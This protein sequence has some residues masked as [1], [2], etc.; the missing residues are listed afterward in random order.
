MSGSRLTSALLELGRAE[1][2]GDRDRGMRAREEIL[3]LAAVGSDAVAR[4]ESGEAEQLAPLRAPDVR[5]RVAA[6]QASRRPVEGTHPAVTAATRT[7]SG[8]RGRIDGQPARLYT[9]NGYRSI[10]RQLAKNGRV[11]WRPAPDGAGYWLTSE[12]AATVR[13]VHAALYED[14]HNAEEVTT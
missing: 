11:E 4:E 6:F 10:V 14:T 8:V 13:K 1:F 3:R 9:G 12:E 2:V 5:D 7:A